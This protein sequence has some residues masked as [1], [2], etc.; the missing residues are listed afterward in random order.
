MVGQ[1]RAVFSTE[2]DLVVVHATIK[3][4]GS[5]TLGAAGTSATCRPHARRL[6]R[7]RAQRPGG[8]AM[9]VEHSRSCLW[10]ERGLMGTGI[11]CLIWVALVSLQ[12]TRY[13]HQQQASLEHLRKSAP[14][15]LDESGVLPTGSLIGSLNIPRLRLSAV[16]AEGDDH[17]TL[18]VAIGHL[19]DTPLPWH[20]GNS[21]LAGHRD[22]WFRPLQHIR[23]GD[24]FYVSTLH[25]DFRYRVRDTMVVG[26]NDV[27]VL[28]P[29]DQPT[30]TLITCYPFSYLGKASRRFIVRAER[31]STA[32]PHSSQK[33]DR[34]TRL[35]SPF[36]EVQQL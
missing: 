10:I 34:T 20:E 18:K 14:A 23:V 35:S 5:I 12:A 29:T 31:T 22:T 3:A 36:L 21:A 2:S 32:D 7:P 17:A 16:I 28:D 13:Q 25:G 33:P 19:T 26:P 24:E 1:G 8:R 4:L 15:V 30:L 11:V 27:W 6:F 9:R